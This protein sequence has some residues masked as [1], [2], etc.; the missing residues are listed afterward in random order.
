[1]SITKA[2]MVPSASGKAGVRAKLSETE[3]IL[4]NN[5][6]PS[7]RKTQECLWSELQNCGLWSRTRQIRKK[8]E[9]ASRWRLQQPPLK[10]MENQSWAMPAANRTDL[11][12]GALHLARAKF[13]SFPSPIGRTGGMVLSVPGQAW[14]GFDPRTRTEEEGESY[15]HRVV[16][17]FPQV[18]CNKCT[19]SPQPHVHFFPSRM[20]TT[21]YH[22][23]GHYANWTFLYQYCRLNPRSHTC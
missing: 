23:L 5:E 21:I 16:F 2:G 3:R 8:Q 13:A 12:S 17:W 4:W 14:L 19:H 22:I 7:S 6:C 18:S 15:S 20:Y 1:M 9:N 11:R 10:R